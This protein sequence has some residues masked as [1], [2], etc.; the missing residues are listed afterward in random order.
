MPTVDEFLNS[1]EAFFAKRGVA[2]PKLSARV[3]VSDTLGLDRLQLFLKGDK[4]L[5]ED[6]LDRLREPVRRRGDGEPVAY[7]QGKRA[8]WSLDFEVGPGVLIPRP[9]TETLVEATLAAI[10]RTIAAEAPALDETKVESDTED[11]TPLV[12]VA[13]ICS[14][15]GCVA[16]AIASERTDVRIYATEASPEALGFLTKNIAAHGLE[17]RITAIQGDLMAP[18][19]PLRPVDWVVSNPPYI[20]TAVLA[21][22]EVKEHEPRLA[23]DGGADGLDV[24]RRLIPEAARRARRGV[25]VEISSDQGDAVA[26]LFRDAGLIDV[27]VKKDPGGRDRVVSGFVR[28]GVRG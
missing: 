22:L 25:L 13:D 19:P 28:G 3:I 27:I 5:S 20:A 15:S 7:I 2:A 21:D 14:G 17:R 11:N 12:F 1:T 4:P 10:K 6:E 26:Q 23:L 18:I 9:A 8:F 16:I 24:Y